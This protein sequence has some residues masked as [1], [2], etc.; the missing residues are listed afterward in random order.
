MINNLIGIQIKDADDYIAI[1]NPADTVIIYKA[2]SLLTKD[3][4]VGPV[5]PLE[6]AKRLVDEAEK[7][8]N[9]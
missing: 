2:Q 7:G 3:G 1:P 5:L 4:L 9:K 8:W 6:E